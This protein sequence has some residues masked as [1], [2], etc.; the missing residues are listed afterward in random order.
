MK[1]GFDVHD[2]DHRMRI[3]LQR[4]RENRRVSLHNRLKILKF[5]DYQE[6]QGVGIARRIKYV[7]NL[8]RLTSM[9]GGKAFE[10]A[11]RSDLEA[12]IREHGRL[13]LSEESDTTFR[14]MVK[15]FYRWL[16]DPNDEEYPPE[17]RW[18]K[19]TVKAN[20]NHLPEEL[21]TQD[22]VMA[23]I[24]AARSTRDRAFIAMLYDSGGRIGE[25]LSL[26]RKNILFDEHG[27]VAIVEGKTGQR[28]DRLILSLPFLA[29]WLNDHPDKR[30]DA[31]LWIHQRQG[32]HQRGIVPMD[33][34]S[35]R[36]LLMRVR[37]T[38]DI[39]KRVNPHAF[40]HARATHLAN[41]LTEAQM[42]EYFGWT[43]DSKMAARYVHLSG[44][45]VDGAILRAHGLQSKVEQDTPKLT[46]VTCV[47][48]GLQNSTVNKFCS[49]CSMPLDLKTALEMKENL[50]KK[51]DEEMQKMRD[52][53][54]ELRFAVRLLQDASGYR[55]EPLKQRNQ[56]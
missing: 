4:M 7:F 22:E 53:L 11:A 30:P 51:S 45:D 17:V 31:P 6:T 35:A 2:F 42:K 52:E 50:S 18:L 13:G 16:K 44:R 26:Q 32:C 24:K 41:I 25:V 56:T 10:K 54:D 55:V 3:A 48:C 47:R 39:K 14:V 40:R 15:R 9:L 21:L 29:E 43:Q 19:G 23:L 36:K 5:L 37:D 38:A 20:R 49:R 33:Y 46:V 12:A 8:A 28:R 27:A 34:A 1:S